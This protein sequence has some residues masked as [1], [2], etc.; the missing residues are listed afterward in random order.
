[1]TPRRAFT[2]IEITIAVAITALLTAAVAMSFTG[3]LQSARAKDAAEAIRSADAS[4]R[5]LA[6][7]S[8]RDVVIGFDLYDQH[9]S[10][11]TGDDEVFHTNLPRGCVIERFRSP[12]RDI[13][14]GE[15][16]VAISR[17]GLSRSYALHLRGPQ[18]DQWI[19]VAGLT[20]ETSIVQHEEI[21]D[22][23]F[24]PPTRHDA[25]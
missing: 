5:V 3:P 21:L 16:T 9:I 23:I 6:R 7:R 15:G 13:S 22:A 4:A 2:L 19:L 24:R 25:D 18:L 20:G 12:E 10:T 8:G 1:M 17:L 11:R 14:S